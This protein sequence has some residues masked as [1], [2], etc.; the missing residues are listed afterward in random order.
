[1]GF[2]SVANQGRPCS[3]Q[4]R[5]R[6]DRYSGQTCSSRQFP[7]DEL[8]SSV[9][10]IPVHRSVLAGHAER[11]SAKADYLSANFLSRS[12]RSATSAKTST[13]VTSTLVT[14]PLV[15]P[16]IRSFPASPAERSSAK[17]EF[18]S[19]KLPATCP[20]PLPI[21]YW[22][23]PS[24]PRPHVNH[25]T[26]QHPFYGKLTRLLCNRTRFSKPCLQLTRN[27]R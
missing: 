20:T 22:P 14:S 19:A 8:C 13:L 7:Q 6:Q 26:A 12:G 17:A 24:S 3:A 27:H 15:R 18:L 23:W 16:I 10:Q 1:M 5:S 4:R 9:P 2:F 21:S 25:F 11:S